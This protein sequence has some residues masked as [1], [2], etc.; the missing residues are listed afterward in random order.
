MCRFSHPRRPRSAMLPQQ[1]ALLALPVLLLLIFAFVVALASSG[2]RQLDLGPAAAVEIDGERHQSH[3]LPRDRAVQ[4]GDLALVEKQ[5][6]R[7]FGLVIVAVAMAELGDVGVDQPDPPLLPPGIGFGDRALAEAKRL[8]FGAGQRDSRLIFVL[9]RIIEPRPPIL[10][11]DLFLVELGGAG[12]DHQRP[13]IPAKAAIALG[14]S[15]T[16]RN[17]IPAFTGLTERE[18]LTAT[19]HAEARRRPRAGSPRRAESSAGAGRRRNRGGR[20]RAHI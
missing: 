5:L 15:E 13:V 9:D 11:D 20:G 1:P 3:P 17:E 7:P 4:F 8:H 12:A 6:A 10:G 16:G 2:Q 18:V 14:F 19:P